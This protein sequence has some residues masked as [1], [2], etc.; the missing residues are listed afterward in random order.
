L[1]SWGVGG[2]YR[3]N[4]PWVSP[5]HPDPLPASGERE[6]TEFA[7]RSN[8]NQR[9]QFAFARPAAV[10]AILPNTE[11]EQSPEPPG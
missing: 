5:P 10:P 11:P 1:F 8:L 6:H 3:Q 9:S 2:H 7:A 4:V